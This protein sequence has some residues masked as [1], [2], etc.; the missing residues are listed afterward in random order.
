MNWC[1]HGDQKTL[2]SYWDRF[3][4]Y[5]SMSD[6]ML[7]WYILPITIFTGWSFTPQMNW[8]W[9]ETHWH[10]L[11]KRSWFSCL[12]RTTLIDTHQSSFTEHQYITKTLIHILLYIDITKCLVFSWWRCEV[13]SICL[14]LAENVRWSTGQN[15]RKPASLYQRP[16]RRSREICT[17]TAERETTGAPVWTDGKRTD[18]YVGLFYILILRNFGFFLLCKKSSCCYF[19]LY[20][21]KV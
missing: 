4:R 12:V 11:S 1:Y 20:C 10:I 7:S 2:Y 17:S 13:L 21:N 16:Q 15:T 9:T 5:F 19:F 18:L 6:F 8:V 3:Y 14:F